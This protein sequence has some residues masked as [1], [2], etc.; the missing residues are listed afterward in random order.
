M[1]RLRVPVSTS[2]LI[3]TV[4]LKKE[5]TLGKVIGKSLQGYGISFGL[6]VFV[7]AL[8][9]PLI[10]KYTAQ[11]P[12]KK[13]YRQ[14]WQVLQWC[15]TSLLW[16]VWL[17]QDMSNVAVSLKRTLSFYEFSL[18]IVFTIMVLG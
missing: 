8:L 13:I 17:M 18:T 11:P 15:T 4:Y 1:T 14:I 16:S 6:A 3:L 5:K 12:E 9:T 7:Y 2:F 10:K